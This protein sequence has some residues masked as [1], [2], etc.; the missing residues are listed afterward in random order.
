M[1]S[2]NDK[3]LH[4]AVQSFIAG[5]TFS[6]SRTHPY[7]HERI[8]NLYVMRDGPRKN[9]KD[10]RNEEW[11]GIAPLPPAEIDRV[12][13]KHTRGRFAVSYIRGEG[14][15][16]MPIRDEFKRLK[17]RLAHTEPLMIHNLRKIPRFKSTVKVQRVQS[18]ELAEALAKEQRKRP[19]H[20]STLA[21]DSPIR[22]YVTLDGNEIVGWVASI[23]AGKSTWVSNM[24]VKLA[25][26]RKG[27]GKVMLCKLLSDDRKAGAKSVVLLASHTGAM[28][29][30][31]VGFEQIGM[32]LLYTPVE[33]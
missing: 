7:V 18:M 9:A 26:R 5:F 22:Q 24:Y 15:D 2:V 31:V 3:T 21:K 28:L 25:H 14:V 19:P 20:E 10:Y 12:A 17:Y 33:R 16:E 11:V 4:A 30:P 32:L 27:I 8:D 6:R 29:Y 1:K 23:S 13:R